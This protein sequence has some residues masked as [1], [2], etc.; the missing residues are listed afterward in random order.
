MCTKDKGRPNSQQIESIKMNGDLRKELQQLKHGV[1]FKDGTDI[2]FSLS[3]AS[4]EMMRAVHIF[5]EVAYM[6]VTPNTSSE[7]CDL[8]LLVVED[9]NGEIYSRCATIIPFQQRGLLNKN[10]FIPP[11]VSW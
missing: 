6:D 3:V 9:T 7:G 10:I 2:F 11:D 5:P 4:D 8:H 1:K